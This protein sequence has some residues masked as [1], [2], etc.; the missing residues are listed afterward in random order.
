MA[1]EAYK[2]WIVIGIAVTVGAIFVFSYMSSPRYKTDV[3][4]ERNAKRNTA[5]PGPLIDTNLNRMPSLEQLEADTDDPRALAR[6]GDTYFEGGNYARAIDIYRKVLVLDPKDIDT[7]N[8][9]GLAYYYSGQA[10]LALDTLR[11]G[12]EIMPSYQ[13]VWLSL[14]FVLMSMG[15]NDEA[16]PALEQ[17]AV[18]DPGTDVVQEEKRML[19]QIK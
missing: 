16:R 10:N 5:P 3:S 4:V 15:K 8:D 6:M 18:L 13:R 19:G 9:L 2:K 7:Y 11:K 14:G 12:T 17:T 1:A